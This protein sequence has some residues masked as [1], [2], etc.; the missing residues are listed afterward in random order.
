MSWEAIDVRRGHPEASIESAGSRLFQCV[1]VMMVWVYG[2]ASLVA[3]TFCLFVAL[4]VAP[5]AWV[6][7]SLIHLGLTKTLLLGLV[8]CVVG[9]LIWRFG[10]WLVRGR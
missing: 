2:G 8:L 10:Y 5:I 1:A 4:V 6:Q 3:V 9:A 7:H